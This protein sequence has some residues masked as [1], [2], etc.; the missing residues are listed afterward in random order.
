M[1]FDQISTDVDRLS[2]LLRQ[3]EVEQ[4]LYNEAALLDTHRFEEW[5]E[6]FA[7]DATYFIPIRRTRMQRE[8]DQEFTKP[9]DMAFLNDTKDLLRGRVAKLAT[10]RSWSEDPPSRTRRLVTN[11]RITH[12]DG[13]EMAV[14][15]NFLLYRTRL[16]SQE[17]TWI[18]SRKDRL[19]RI[20]TGLCIA[21]R[22]VLL[23]QTVLLARN[24][25][26][27]F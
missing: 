2:A 17:D 8:L 3:H 20:D 15:S 14:E 21:G 1:T 11:V 25:S 4:F 6:L 10:G 9:G 26:N 16:N 27:F 12:D 7:D 24:L 22:T 19:R 23:E 5:L 18:G 13:T